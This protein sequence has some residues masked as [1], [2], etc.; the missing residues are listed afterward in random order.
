VAELV[1]DAAL[2]FSS[3]TTYDPAKHRY[4][5]RGMVGPDEFHT[6]YPGRP[7]P[8]IDDNAYTN[9]LVV[10]LL[11]T[12]LRVLDTLTPTQ[13]ETVVRR[14]GVTTE[15]RRRWQS[16]ATRM[17]VPFRD[18][19]LLQLEGYDRLAELAW[20]DYRERTCHGSEP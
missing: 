16:F 6:G 15:D 12:A 13:A 8:G 10:W 4:M 2:F 11:R 19:L 18:G 9:L 7:G 17:F 3:L 5:L 14:V 1:L 20:D